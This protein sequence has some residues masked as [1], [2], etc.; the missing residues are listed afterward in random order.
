MASH[1]EEIRFRSVAPVFLVAD[2]N[3]TAAWY[4]EHLRFDTTGLFPRQGRY[5]V[6]ASLQ[7]GGAEIMLQ[8]LEGYQKAPV[9]DRRDGGVW[10]AYF[11]VSGVREFYQTVKGQAFVKM[12]LRKQPYGHWEFELQDLNGYVLAFGGDEDVPADAV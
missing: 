9:Y 2:V 3:K 11:R 5:A 6:W 4:S 10:D 7:R 8:R 1:P 12:P